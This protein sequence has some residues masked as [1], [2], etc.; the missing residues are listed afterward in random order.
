MKIKN[1]FLTLL[2]V[3][4]FQ[5]VFSGPYFIRGKIYDSSGV[6]GTAQTENS[7]ASV[8]I[9]REGISGQIG[10]QY[11]G[12]DPLYP[13]KIYPAGYEYVTVSAYCYTDVGSYYWSTPAALSQTV[14]TVFQVANG[15]N[16]WS[17]ATYIGF[18][19]GLIT[20]EDLINST[21]DLPDT[22]LI[23]LPAPTVVEFDM[24]HIT[25][26]WVGLEP[27]TISN[28]GLYRYNETDGVTDTVASV[29][30]T[31]GV[32]IIYED[33]DIVP[34][35]SYSYMISVKYTDMG[36]EIP[37]EYETSV[38][39]LLSESVL[40]P[41]PSPTIT[42]TS[43]ITPTITITPTTTLTSTITVTFTITMTSTPTPTATS[44]AIYQT[45]KNSKWTAFVADITGNTYNAVNAYGELYEIASGRN[46]VV[47]KGWAKYNQGH[48]LIKKF[49][50]LTNWNQGV[51]AVR[52]V[53]T[54]SA[55]ATA[56]ANFV[57]TAT[58]VYYLLIEAS[59][60]LNAAATVGS[61][62]ATNKIKVD[63]NY[64]SEVATYIA[65]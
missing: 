22:Q 55:Q 26:S 3:L 1:L 51:K 65:E 23:E 29:T 5:N 52:L 39:S 10:G 62:P 32:E 58:P 9:F 49:R 19:G 44:T 4:L 14:R 7:F 2:L 34:G 6:T 18:T 41:L 57:A 54:P 8:V 28:Y 40:V 38:K 46:S 12:P 53:R 61:T 42:L 36:E 43:T 37:V 27:A 24:N 31:A 11:N 35:K 21:T 30:Q 45:V 63:N 25:I 47:E 20:E 48:V 17:G 15:I 13:N 60:Y 50:S 16:G 59:T 56:K 33:T 64:V